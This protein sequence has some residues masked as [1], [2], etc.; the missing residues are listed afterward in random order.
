MSKKPN[1]K[2]KTKTAKQSTDFYKGLSSTISIIID[3]KIKIDPETVRDEI[4]QDICE[5]I[6]II[7]SEIQ[8][9]R[10]MRLREFLLNHI[11]NKT[12]NEFIESLSNLK[13]I[14]HLASRDV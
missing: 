11:D 9:M 13:I 3:S 8:V 5:A 1:T 2:T 4:V 7:D 6:S 10:D 14:D 12:L